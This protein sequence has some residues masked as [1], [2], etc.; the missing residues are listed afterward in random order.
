MRTITE[1]STTPLLTVLFVRVLAG[2]T[3]LVAVACSGGGGGGGDNGGSSG[4]EEAPALVSTERLGIPLVA[5]I[6]DQNL[7]PDD[8]FSYQCELLNG[9]LPVSWAVDDTMDNLGMTISSTGLISWTV[10]PAGGGGPDS[11]TVKVSATNS[12]GT[13]EKSFT[14]NV[15]PGDNSPPMIQELTAIGDLSVDEVGYLCLSAT[16]SDAEDN[17]SS[18]EASVWGDRPDPWQELAIE[19]VGESATEYQWLGEVNPLSSGEIHITFRVTDTQGATTEG[20]ATTLV[21]AVNSEP[22]GDTI[23]LSAEE[24][25]GQDGLLVYNG[26]ATHGQVPVRGNVLVG[27]V[28]DG[29]AY[30]YHPDLEGEGLSDY[31]SRRALG[32]FIQQLSES[33]ASKGHNALTKTDVLVPTSQQ[34]FKNPDTGCS[35]YPLGAQV[36]LP[37]GMHVEADAA[38]HC[39][40]DNTTKR[41]AAIKSMTGDGPYFLAPETGFRMNTFWPGLSGALNTLLKVTSGAGVIEDSVQDIDGTPV[42]A[43]CS[44]ARLFPF[45]YYLPSVYK[46]DLIAQLP[47]ERLRFV[48]DYFISDHPV[49]EAIKERLPGLKT[50]VRLALEDDPKLFVRVNGLDAGC[51]CV[52]GLKN[53]AGVIPSEIIEAPFRAFLLNIVEISM[54][55]F[56][57]EWT[58]EEGEGTHK[59]TANFIFTS[60]VELLSSFYQCVGEGI[61]PPVFLV[62]NNMLDAISAGAWVYDEL[63][64]IQDTLEYAAFDC[65]EFGD[66]VTI[67]DAYLAEVLNKALGRSPTAGNTFYV[68][69]LE[70]LEGFGDYWGTPSG[71]A[72]SDFTGVQFCKN[73][74]VI[75]FTNVDLSEADLGPIGQLPLLEELVLVWA[76]LSD[77]TGLGTLPG[78]KTLH[79]YRNDIYDISELASL[80]SLTEIALGYNNI[81]SIE[82]LSSLTSLEGIY[83][84]YNLVEDLAPLA[85]LINLHEVTFSHNPVADIS[86]LVNNPGIGPGDIIHMGDNSLYCECT[87]GFD[88]QDCIDSKALR[89]KG[90]E[91]YGCCD[92]L[93][94]CY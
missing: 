84:E 72:I 45:I 15:Y 86:G 14:L 30:L 13:D 49:A 27:A 76:G 20:T 22:T 70:S 89:A 53:L 39:T 12:A 79:L 82:P 80:S 35:T 42:K 8:Q 58:A 77:L 29:K 78:I 64:G 34:L 41:W 40:I 24:I 3:L 1:Y 69:E 87:D 10:P 57:T 11:Y 51:M 9:D 74:T 55:D 71:H 50:R 31:N 61:A 28:K 38:D 91:V 23:I 17:I 44:V 2:I 93:E 6:Y 60:V 92:I 88:T 67:P 81:S 56:F 48:V 7:H 43:Y 66:Q 73:V 25:A 62:I 83:M 59:Q 63:A 68:S 36:K 90:T 65:L 47:D 85:G 18:V 4:A 94:C 21:K 26:Y 32:H 75:S 33:P 46:E 19:Y 54:V 52:E 37:S 5:K 16:I